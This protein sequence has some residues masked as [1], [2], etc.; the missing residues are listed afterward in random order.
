MAFGKAPWVHQTPLRVSQ[1]DAAC[2][3]VS[4]GDPSS[5]PPS[6]PLGGGVSDGAL[7]QRVRR[8]E[9]HAEVARARV[10]RLRAQE[11]HDLLLQRAHHA[12]QV[13][14]GHGVGRVQIHYGFF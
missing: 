14:A 10:L 8:H 4:L 3:G 11:G 1:S 9:Q 2:S 12:G 13:L 6:R 5:R 7:E